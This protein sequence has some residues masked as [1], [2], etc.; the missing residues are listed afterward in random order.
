MR[1]APCGEGNA[2]VESHGERG[3]RLL[4]GPSMRRFVKAK[5]ELPEMDEET[6]RNL[7]YWKRWLYRVLRDQRA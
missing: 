2:Q 5:V 3:R 4:Q 6:I 1:H 7:P